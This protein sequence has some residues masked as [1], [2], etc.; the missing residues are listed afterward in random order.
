MMYCTVQGAISSKNVP[1]YCGTEQTTLLVA[2]A[3]YFYYEHSKHLGSTNILGQ[4]K[5]TLCLLA[6]LFQI[7][8]PAMNGIR[9]IPFLRNTLR[10]F[11]AECI[12]PTNNSIL[13]RPFVEY[14]QVSVGMQQVLYRMST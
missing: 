1:P 6:E 14:R 12:D 9:G 8:L 10:D 5:I 4:T 2:H 3:V 7:V 13:Y 11:E